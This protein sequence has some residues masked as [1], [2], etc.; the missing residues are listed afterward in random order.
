M[1][2]HIVVVG[3][4]FAGI[5]F[6]LDLAG[7]KDYRIT[8]VDRNN[9]NFFPPLLYQIATGFLEVANI[10]YPFRK[11]FRRKENLYYYMGEFL[12]VVPEENK[13]VLSTGELHYDYLV[14]A[15]GTVSNYFGNAN[16]EKFAKPMKTVND[17][18]R[19]RNFVLEQLEWASMTRDD[20]E[21]HKYLN[22]VIAGGG[23]TG[24]EVAGM[25]ADLRKYILYKDYPELKGKNHGARIYLVDGGEVLLK[26]MSKEAQQETMKSLR[27][28]GVEIIL[29][30][31]VE[32]YDGE[33]IKLSDGNTIPAKTLIWAAGVTGTIFEGIPSDVY[34]HGKR[35]LTDPYCRVKGFENIYAIGDISL[36]LHE[37]NYPQGHPQL[38]QA[39]I[40]QGHALSKNF[41]KLALNQELEAFKYHD[42]GTMAII[43]RNK[44]VVDLSEK[45]HFKGFIAWMLWIFVHLL[46]LISY[47]NRITTLYNWA[48]A[49]FTKDQPL[50]M[51]IR[52][53]RKKQEV[54]N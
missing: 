9:Y 17:A 21:R 7:N 44:A 49:Y 46:S 42:K 18:L 39:A 5:N 35:L 6:A 11:L 16:I 3:G 36:Q 4:G 29:D 41:K 32:D 28:M 31:H 13:V 48:V 45:V 52:P 54:L 2:K 33:T 25:L 43:G 15:T 1:L 34:G 19:L 20:E 14:L 10:S 38:A 27:E 51:I 40:Q 37:A 47:R 26:P 50:R 22:I 24:V 23:P 12:E 8:L 30:M 53:S